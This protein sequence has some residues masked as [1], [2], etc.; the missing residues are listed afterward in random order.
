MAWLGHVIGL[1][2][3]WGDGVDR[4]RGAHACYFCGRE[5]AAFSLIKKGMLTL[6]IKGVDHFCRLTGLKG[7]QIHRSFRGTHPD[8]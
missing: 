8:V 6:K 2:I 7:F 3:R 4:K 1:R 5:A